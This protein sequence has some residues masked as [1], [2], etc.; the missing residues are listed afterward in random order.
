MKIISILSL[1]KGLFEI[2]VLINMG[3]VMTKLK[4]VLWHLNTTFMKHI[5]TMT[6]VQNKR[7]GWYIEELVSACAFLFVVI[8]FT[9]KDTG[10][11][12]LTKNTKES[13]K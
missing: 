11:S 8:L 10:T 5:L 7:S 12:I 4:L 13:A 2:L 1:S 6:K 3:H 9:T